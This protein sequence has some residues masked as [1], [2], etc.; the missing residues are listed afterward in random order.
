VD[1]EG[2]HIAYFEVR[3]AVLQGKINAKK[4]SEG[5]AFTCIWPVRFAAAVLIVQRSLSSL[6]W[7]DKC[8]RTYDRLFTKT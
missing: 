7:I 3:I 4:T 5:T 2:D 6:K 8:Y 1:L